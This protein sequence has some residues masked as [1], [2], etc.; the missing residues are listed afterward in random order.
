MVVMFPF[1]AKHWFSVR[2]NCYYIIFLLTLGLLVSLLAG[3]AYNLVPTQMLGHSECISDITS[4]PWWMMFRVVISVDMYFTPNVLSLVV[5]AILIIKIH[6]ELSNRT[7]LVRSHL[8][9]SN[10]DQRLN[11]GLSDKQR[12]VSFSQISGSLTAVT[13]AILHAIFYMPD[14]I[15]GIYFYQN[16]A[17]PTDPI[18]I[19]KLWMLYLFTMAYTSFGCLTDFWV[20]TIRIPVFRATLLCRSNQK[21][22]ISSE[23]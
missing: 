21:I 13:M 10:Q 19:P 1:N 15:F 11:N 16:L 2:F 22:S 6:A 18:I 12:T 23:Q 8:Y 20:Y 3:K 17:N 7:A 5:A 14:A 4:N 9:S